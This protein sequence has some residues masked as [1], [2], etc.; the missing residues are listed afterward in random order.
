MT[1]KHRPFSPGNYMIKLWRPLSQHLSFYDAV[2]DPLISTGGRK[3]GNLESASRYHLKGTHFSLLYIA[4][5][6]S[7][8]GDSL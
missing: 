4:F 7:E 2:E 1:V 6:L 3:K 5:E 8:A